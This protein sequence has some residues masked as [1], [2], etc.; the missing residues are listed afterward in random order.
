MGIVATAPSITTAEIGSKVTEI[1]SKMGDGMKVGGAGL[2]R[3]AGVAVTAIFSTQSLGVDSD[4]IPGVLGQPDV[5]LDQDKV[6]IFMG[7]KTKAEPK[8]KEKADT[9]TDTVGGTPSNKKCKDESHRGNI[10]A[11]EETGMLVV[12]PAISRWDLPTPPGFVFATAAANAVRLALFA[13]G[14]NGIDLNPELGL[15]KGDRGKD[16]QKGA[17]KAHANI[18]KILEQNKTTGIYSKYEISC[19]FN[20]TKAFGANKALKKAASRRIDLTVH[21]GQLMGPGTL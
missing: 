21:K 7:S 6:G 13:Q 19:Y 3:V 17:D 15:V 16:F 1:A 2:L 4:K 5:G 12:T 18:L 9:C 14:E 11:Q 8:V 10:Q 20:G